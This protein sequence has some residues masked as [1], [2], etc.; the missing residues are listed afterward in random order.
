M[1][2]Y[3]RETERKKISKV[4]ELTSLRTKNKLINLRRRVKVVFVLFEYTNCKEKEREREKVSET[5]VGRFQFARARSSGSGSFLLFSR[6]ILDEN[7]NNFNKTL[8]TTTTRERERER[9]REERKTHD[10][11]RDQQKLESVDAHDALKGLDVVFSVHIVFNLRV[12]S[13]RNCEARKVRKGTF[14]TFFE[15]FLLFLSLSLSLSLSSLPFNDRNRSQLD[16]FL[17]NP[18]VVAGIHDLGDVFITLRRFFHD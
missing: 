10:F 3:S 13:D 16:A 14:Y 11:L 6:P 2:Y 15:I 17:A 8:S 9:E 1:S 4:G 5:K 7:W 12:K 18:G